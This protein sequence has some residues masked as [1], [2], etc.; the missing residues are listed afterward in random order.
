MHFKG[1][2]STESLIV[3]GFALVLIFALIYAVL[4]VMLDFTQFSDSAQAERS[5]SKLTGTIDAVSAYGPG[6][7][8]TLFLYLPAGE[9]TYSNGV[10]VF[11]VQSSG[12]QIVKKVRVSNV[13]Y[14]NPN[15]QMNAGVKRIKIS[16]KDD[17]SGVEVKVE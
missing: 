16:S 3:M 8:T 10:F 4:P 1:Q 11:A 6:T 12:T 9:L 17:L 14:D 13:Y 5:L 7:N 15:P 2:A